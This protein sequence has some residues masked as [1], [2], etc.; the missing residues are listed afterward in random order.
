MLRNFLVGELGYSK[1]S[2]KKPINKIH[3]IFYLKNYPDPKTISVFLRINL[4]IKT[5]DQF[6]KAYNNNRPHN[7]F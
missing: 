2:V 4:H 6:E 1:S 7:Y 5:L 3:L